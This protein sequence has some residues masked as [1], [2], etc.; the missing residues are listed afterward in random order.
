[1]GEFHH[2]TAR[3]QSWDGLLGGVLRPAFFSGIRPDLF[4]VRRPRFRRGLLCAAGVCRCR[5]G[6]ADVDGGAGRGA[7][8]QGGM[9]HAYPVA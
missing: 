9:I 3:S 1:M 5:A 4:K 7:A 8:M 6:N 2:E